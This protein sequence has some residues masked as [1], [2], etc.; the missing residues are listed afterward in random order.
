MWN[1]IYMQRIECY[2]MDYRLIWLTIFG[3][4]SFKKNCFLLFVFLFKPIIYGSIISVRFLDSSLEKTT[5]HWK[6]HSSTKIIIY[7]HLFMKKIFFLLI[8]WFF[9]KRW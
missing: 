2:K 9:V 1:R 8:C 5:F 7:T 6:I 3:W 4:Y